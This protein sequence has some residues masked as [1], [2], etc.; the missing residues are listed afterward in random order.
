[1]LASGSLECLMLIASLNLSTRPGTIIFLPSKSSETK[2]VE[3][4]HVQVV[5]FERRKMASL[6]R[7]W[8]ERL[9]FV[10]G[11]IAAVVLTLVKS[12]GEREVKVKIKLIE[13]CVCGSNT[14]NFI[15]LTPTGK[16]HSLHII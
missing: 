14:C 7:W 16:L 4:V 13:T 3:V 9:L 12:G 15:L 5:A 8:I 11:A 1:M 2:V 6:Y 10:L